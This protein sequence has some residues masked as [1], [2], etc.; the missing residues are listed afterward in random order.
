MIDWNLYLHMADN[1]ES[2]VLALRQDGRPVIAERMAQLITAVRCL[3]KDNTELRAHNESLLRQLDAA[4]IRFQRVHEE[5][6]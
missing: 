5:A 6:S 1:A 2:V 4:H 3:H